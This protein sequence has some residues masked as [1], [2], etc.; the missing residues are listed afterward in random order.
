M[1]SARSAISNTKPAL[2]PNFLVNAYM[3]MTPT[4]GTRAFEVMGGDTFKPRTCMNNRSCEYWR[5]RHTMN[6]SMHA[7]PSAKATLT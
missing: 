2:T 3:G 1:R 4:R 7:M 5:V 6:T